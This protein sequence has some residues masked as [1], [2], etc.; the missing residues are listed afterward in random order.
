MLAADGA[1]LVDCATAAGGAP[2]VS[3]VLTGRTLLTRNTALR[4]GDA[5]RFGDALRPG[6]A[7]ILTKPLGSGIILEGFRRGLAEARWL[8]DAVASMTASSAAAVRLLRQHGAT[9]CAAVAQH[10]LVGT[11]ASLL[12]DANLAAVLTADA[13][14]ALTGARDLAALGRG[15][16]RGRREPPGL[17]RSAGL[18]GPCAACRSADR[19]RAAGGR[20]AGG[21]ASCL[22]ELR[23]AGYD[24]ARIGQA[25]A[26]RLDMPRL[27]LE[28]APDAAAGAGA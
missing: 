2:A 14:P 11:L 20:A 22:A 9:A 26:R 8:L 10:G 3:L 4:P 1:L 28:P 16:R 18:A 19:R 24:A 27:R 23:A 13:I 17:A 7:L 21:A 6:D 15:A 5:A 25:E 12:R